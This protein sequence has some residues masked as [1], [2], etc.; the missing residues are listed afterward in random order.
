MVGPQYLMNS[1]QTPR[2]Y[3]EK[4]RLYG[5]FVISQKNTSKIGTNCFKEVKL[6]GMATKF[7]F[8]KPNSG[9]CIHVQHSQTI[10]GQ[11]NQLL[12]T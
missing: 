10:Y 11:N 8:E 12:D 7:K 4:F 5:Y 3:G 2:L 9:F 1:I 6:T